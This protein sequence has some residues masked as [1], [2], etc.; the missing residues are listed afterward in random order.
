MKTFEIK[1]K[2]VIYQV[3][4]IE[5]NPQVVVID[6]LHFQ[7]AVA[8]ANAMAWYGHIDFNNY[9]KKPRWE[10]ISN[11]I[12]NSGICK[13]GEDE[14]AAKAAIAYMESI[15]W[16]SL[17]MMADFQ[18]AKKT[19]WVIQWA[20][21]SGSRVY[22]GIP[23]EHSNIPDWDSK[24]NEKTQK[25]ISKEEAEEV[26]KSNRFNIYFCKAVGLELA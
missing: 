11:S 23:I 18:P 9:D 2:E 22:M 6:P 1:T 24:I 10:T 4:K 7:I 16:D 8:M 26:I 12:R 13:M 21:E 17:K 14:A 5:P 3:G 15:H 20:F 19:I 25:F